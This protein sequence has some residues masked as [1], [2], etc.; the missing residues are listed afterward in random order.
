MH[1]DGG[2]SQYCASLRSQE[3]NYSAESLQIELKEVS[4]KLLVLS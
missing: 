1:I 4:Q 3:L 2:E